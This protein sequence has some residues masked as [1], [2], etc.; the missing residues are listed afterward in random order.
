M[1]IHRC[2]ECGSTF[3]QAR[4]LRRH[5]RVHRRLRCPHCSERFNDRQALER[6]L[7]SHKKTVSTQTNLQNNLG[8]R[9]LTP[10]RH[11]QQ[12]AAPPP[13]Q[14]YHESEASRRARLQMMDPLNLLG[15][16]DEDEPRRDW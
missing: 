3:T 2:E 16:S 5:Q 4:R 7:P 8:C 13:P 11:R 6:H 10:T 14:Q 12:Q 9:L 1:A 15:D